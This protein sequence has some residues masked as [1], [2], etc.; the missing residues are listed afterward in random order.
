[1]VAGVVH[2]YGHFEIIGP[3]LGTF[4]DQSVFRFWIKVRNDP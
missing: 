4:S 2:R 1:M 3:A